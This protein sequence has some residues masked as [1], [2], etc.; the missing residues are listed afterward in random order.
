MMRF[1][2]A[3]TFFV[4]VGVTTFAKNFVVTNVE[5]LERDLTGSL[6]IVPDESGIACAVLKITI[7]GMARFGG[8]IYGEPTKKGNEYTIYIST[9]ANELKIYPDNAYTLNI[10]LSA[11]PCYPYSPKVCYGMQV[12]T[13]SDEVSGANLDYLSNEDLQTKAA[14]DNAEACFILGCSYYIGLRGFDVDHKKGH[15]WLYRAAKQGHAA[16]QCELGKLYLNGDEHVT[17]NT[18]IAYQWIKQAADNNNGNAQYLMA[19]KY[20]YDITN[21]SDIDIENAKFWLNKSISNKFT[22]AYLSLSLV[23]IKQ[24][25]Y[26]DAIKYAEL[27]AYEGIP[28]GQ[29]LLGSLYGLEAEKFYDPE[30][31]EFWLELAAE[32]GLPQAQFALGQYYENLNGDKNKSEAKFWYNEAA[33]NGNSDAKMALTK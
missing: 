13:L 24:E 11:Y 7:P 25:N 23:N 17:K 26:D 27:L 16:A 2:C 30:K 5:C 3:L 32:G 20:C 29:F 8:D 10:D 6:N 15:E 31:S 14:N 28:A 21:M 1:F 18:D 19:L 33:K 22:F 9:K 4:F 12:V